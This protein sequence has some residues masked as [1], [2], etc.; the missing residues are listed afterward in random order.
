MECEGGA[1]DGQ[2]RRVR[3]EALVGSDGRRGSSPGL[4]V[5]CVC[6]PL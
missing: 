2:C 1:R 5:A 6:L 4:V 3:G